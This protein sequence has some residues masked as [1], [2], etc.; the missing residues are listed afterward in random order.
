MKSRCWRLIV[1]LKRNSVFA[2]VHVRQERISWQG[3]TLL[4]PSRIFQWNNANKR[5]SSD[6]R[7]VKN[8]R[9]TNKQILYKQ[10]LLS[11]YR[12]YVS[13]TIFL[14]QIQLYLHSSIGT[15]MQQIFS[16]SFWFYFKTEKS[17]PQK[18]GEKAESIVMPRFLTCMYVWFQ[19]WHEKILEPHQ[20]P[21]HNY[22]MAQEK[23]KVS[24]LDGL[25]VPRKARNYV[26]Q[27]S[28]LIL[29]V[30]LS[31]RRWD[32]GHIV[33]VRRRGGWH[34]SGGTSRISFFL[35]LFLLLLLNCLLC[36]FICG[37]NEQFF[38]VCFLAGAPVN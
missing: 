18:T 21:C 26:R 28:E 20:A 9:I 16:Q 10:S 17:W 19:I 29:D 34:C 32:G 23:W 2:C 38:F 13:R 33:A 36:W 35:R 5:K 25:S 3:L 24:I 22:L 30:T 12:Q 27:V 14:K 37:V 31:S 1:G 7:I 11:N 8:K 4:S 15:A 6:Y